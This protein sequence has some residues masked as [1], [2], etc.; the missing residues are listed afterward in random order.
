M[1]IPILIDHDCQQVA[2]RMYVDS[3]N[4]LKILFT[5]PI[6]RDLLEELFPGIGYRANFDDNWKLTEAEIYEFSFTPDMKGIEEVL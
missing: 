6:S 2:G 3:S 5:K 1:N 4:K